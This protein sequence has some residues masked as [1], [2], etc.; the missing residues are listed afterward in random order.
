MLGVMRTEG[1]AEVLE[2]RRRIAARMF[3]QGYDANMIA[4]I[5]GVHPQTVRAWHRQ[6][7]AGGLSVLAARPHA[8]PPC[9]L[10]RSQKQQLLERLAQSPTVY[11]YGSHLWTT[12]LIGRLIHDQFG[13]D[14]HHDHVGVMLHQL[15]YSYQKPAKRAAERDEAKIRQ[16][17]RR[18]WPR[19]ERCSRKRQSTLVF[20]DEAGFSMVP[21]IRK[22]WAPRGQTPV[23]K[24]RNRWFRKVSVIGGLTVSANRKN[25][26]LYLDWYPGEHID[27][28]KVA[29]FLEHLVAQITGPLNIVWDNLSAHGG[30]LI[31]AFLSEHPHVELHRLPPY[32][33]ELNPIEM[34]WSLSKYHRLANHGIHDLDELSQRAREAVDEVAAQPTLLRACIEHAGLHHALWPR[35]GQ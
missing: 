10:D 33:P 5:V 35:R 19:I 11:G 30:K 13:V 12:R 27:Q 6:Y 14:Y 16:W 4:D 3:E 9:K 21:S 15:G 26:G 32:A 17:R 25:L 23:V 34:L 18:A 31:R 28:A 2:E 8:G 1:N 24:H 22:Q 7:E 29:H 20:V